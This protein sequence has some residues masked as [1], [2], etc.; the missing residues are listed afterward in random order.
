MTVRRTVMVGGAV[1]LA[2][3]VVMLAVLEMYGVWQIMLGKID[4][5]A[6]LWPS[7]I[8]LP[9]NWCCT[10][11]GIL[12]TISSVAINCLVYIAIALLLRA[13]IRAIKP[14]AAPGSRP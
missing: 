3:S 9:I 10:V 14:P 8:M 1:G 5:R 4:L 12:T 7:S 13:G 2:V 6:V 11:G